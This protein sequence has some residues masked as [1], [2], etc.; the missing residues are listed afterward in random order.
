MSGK[1]YY[2]QTKKVLSSDVNAY[3]RLRL[4]ELFTWLAEISIAHTEKLGAGRAK[5]LDK[6]V[7]WVLARVRLSVKEFPLYDE[8]VTLSTHT[9]PQMHV[10][11]PRGY[12]M[13]SEDGS[14]DYLRMSAV[15]LLLDAKKRKIAFPEKL[16]IAIDGAD[17]ANDLPI[18]SSTDNSATDRESSFRTTFS[19]I[20]LNGHLNNAR[21]LDRMEDILGDKYLS[22]HALRSLQ[23]EYKAEIKPNTKVTVKWTEQ[24]GAVYMQGCVRNK[25]CFTINA[26]YSETPQS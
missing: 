17:E 26:T 25:V 16:G 9:K 14:K 22:C 10:L 4:S 8:T 7:L 20:D 1:F 23:I 3:R 15:W 6:G 12:S 11:F 24:N 5:T 19:Q 18:A 21:Y 2:S 13:D